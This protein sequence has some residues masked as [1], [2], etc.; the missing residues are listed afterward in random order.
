MMNI[1]T[2]FLIHTTLLSINCFK[3]EKPLLSYFRVVLP[4][5]SF[6]IDVFTL[7]VSGRILQSPVVRQ[8]VQSAKYIV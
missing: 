1:L 7:S 4:N 3:V 5:F 8:A 2:H 6:L